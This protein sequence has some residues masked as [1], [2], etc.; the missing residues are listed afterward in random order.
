MAN[1]IAFKLVKDD[2]LKDVILF[3]FDT[4]TRAEGYSNG[5]KS[6]TQG[7]ELE[8][9]I[10]LKKHSF[11]M[12]YSYYQNAHNQVD[13]IKIEGKDDLFLAFPH[14]KITFFGTFALSKR[15]TMS[16]SIWY[17]GEKYSYE[18]FDMNNPDELKLVLHK[19]T[20]N[21]NINFRMENVFI[22]NLDCSLGLY[23]LLNQKNYFVSPLNLGLYPL[24]DQ[25]TEFILRFQY[26][27]GY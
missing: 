12:A 18:P 24:P 13:E 6:G 16:P 10:N 26:N 2:K 19:P 7:F 9:N 15:I 25:R 3:T 11:T 22:K 8:G 17:S 21:W 5:A 4:Q 23:N 14:Q 20:L 1:Y 27:L